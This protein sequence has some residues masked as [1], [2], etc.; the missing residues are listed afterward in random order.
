MK[1][2]GEITNDIIEF[3][4]DIDAY[5]KKNDGITLDSFEFLNLFILNGIC[6]VNINV[7]NN[8]TFNHKDDLSAFKTQFSQLLIFLLNI[9]RNGYSDKCE[10]RMSHFFSYNLLCILLQVNYS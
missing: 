3:F 1:F 5:I 7:L 10:K 4:K 9:I 6:R 8:Q 2:G